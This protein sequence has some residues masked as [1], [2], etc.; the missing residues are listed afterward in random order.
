MHT[1]AEIEPFLQPH[2]V[3]YM[4]KQ[5]HTLISAFYFAG[6][7]RVLAASRESVVD[8]LQSQFTGLTPEQ[9]ALIDQAVQ[10]RD[11]DELK[12]YLQKLVPYVI[13]FPEITG[14]EIRKLFPK[15]K[16][17]MLPD[18]AHLDR[19]RI[20]YLGWRDVAT[21]A[22]Y[23]VR[24]IGGKWVGN[25]CRYL[26]GQ[27]GRTYM[28]SWCGRGF[29]GDGVA[30]VTKQLKVKNVQ[31][32]YKTIGHHLCLDSQACNDSLTTITDME[33]FLSTVK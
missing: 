3:N 7:Y 2:Q 18:L 27:R 8:N 33:T 19:S 6:D 1:V 15:V 13:P 12:A 14:A 23:F 11:R 29:A 16:K 28:C 22:I 17:L 5:I 9:T 4:R 30:L 24:R 10:V 32:G 21:N 20:E 25:E 26:L 31:D